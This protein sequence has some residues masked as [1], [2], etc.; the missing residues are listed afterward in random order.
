MRG[1]CPLLPDTPPAR[2]GASARPWSYDFSYTRDPT[3]ALDWIIDNKRR[4]YRRTGQHDI[5]CCGW[6]ARLLR[7]LTEEA[8]EDFGPRF[9]VMRIDGEIVSAVMSLTAGDRS[10]LW[11]PAYNHAYARY[12]PGMLN[13]MKMLEAAAAEGCRAFDFGPGEEP[14][15]AYF[16]NPA[17]PVA[18]GRLVANPWRTSISRTLA[19]S[20][21]G[22]LRR[23]LHV[24][25]ACETSLAGWTR[26]LATVARAAAGLSYRAA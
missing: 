20:M 11:F 13:T 17:K 12:G 14:Y 26:G 23:R 25:S 8:N 3:D 10:H 7:R 9:S 19:G 4:Q 16:C 1:P 22:R 15:K 2:Q 6:T 5:F 24:V 18:E 21:G